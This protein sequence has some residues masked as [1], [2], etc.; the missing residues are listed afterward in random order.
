MGFNF[1]TFAKEFC[2]W[3]GFC[4]IYCHHPDRKKMLPPF[5]PLCREDK[6]PIAKVNGERDRG[7]L[8]K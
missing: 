7:A 6:C 3:A 1:R 2:K 4:Q 8:F 5:S